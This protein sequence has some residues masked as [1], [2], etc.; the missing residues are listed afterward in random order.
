M[1]IFLLIDHRYISKNDK[2]YELE[3]SYG[4]LPNTLE[5]Q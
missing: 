3:I 4:N 5:V 2:I 1:Q